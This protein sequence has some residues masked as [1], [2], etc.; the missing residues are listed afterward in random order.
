[1]EIYK[2]HIPMTSSTDL[3]SL[4]SNIE[5]ISETYPLSKQ[6]NI[7][8]CLD[9]LPSIQK[10]SNEEFISYDEYKRR[11]EVLNDP[12]FILKKDKIYYSG[13]QTSR[14]FYTQSIFFLLHPNI[15]QKNF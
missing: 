1:M 12:T 7:S 11:Q 14:I 3:F 9:N 13:Q 5:N 8:L 6:D 10:K 15:G 4:A 2:F